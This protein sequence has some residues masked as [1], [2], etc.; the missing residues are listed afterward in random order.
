[1]L[2]GFYSE[3]INCRS[4]TGS[5][6]NTNIDHLTMT[7]QELNQLLQARPTTSSSA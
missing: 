5:A 4:A 6:K 1:M 3:Q 7:A 2:F